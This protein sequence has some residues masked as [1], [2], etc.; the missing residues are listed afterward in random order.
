[1][2]C[3]LLLIT[4]LAFLLES[5]LLVWF[6]LAGVRARLL[7]S[8]L[9]LIGAE[10]GADQGAKCGFLAG[11]LCWLA[12]ASPW[13]MAL[14]TTLGGISGKVFHNATSFWG[15]WL[16]CLL[17]LAALETLRI[18]GHWLTGAPLLA[19][20]RI[21][22][23]EWLLSAACFPLAVLL[24]ALS[25]KKDTGSFRAAKSRRKRRRYKRT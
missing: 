15:K 10:Q 19:G 9:F 14:L 17:P 12:G 1:M 22:G 11:A 13:Q 21:A 3:R 20:L 4:G 23:P 6:P 8:L 25:K 7:P 2:T 24:L 5:L 16:V 18:L